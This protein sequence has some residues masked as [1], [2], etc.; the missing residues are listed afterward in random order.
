MCW[1]ATDLV[2]HDLGVCILPES[3]AARLP[4]LAV[5]RFATYAPTWKVMVVRPAVT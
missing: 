5:V 2:R 4:D 3:P 1:S